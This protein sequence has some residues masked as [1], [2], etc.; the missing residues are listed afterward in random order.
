MKNV[1]SFLQELVH[2]SAEIGIIIAEVIGI[3]ILIITAVKSFIKYFRKDERI[4]LEL[5]QGIA[6]ALEF[7]LGGEVLHTVTVSQDDWM[8]LLFLG[9]II[10]L[11]GVLTLL[12][13][14]EIKIEEDKEHLEMLDQQNDI[15]AEQIAR[16]KA[17][18]AMAAEEAAQK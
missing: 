5:A 7:K 1:I 15:M 13:H 11:R 3:A 4:R 9:G 17:D 16:Q 18:A 2:V 14:W 12:L 8:A 10:A 6:L